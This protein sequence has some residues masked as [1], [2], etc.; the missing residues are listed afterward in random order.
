MAHKNYSFEFDTERR[1]R[2][3]FE[4]SPDA[5][6]R[7]DMNVQAGIPCLLLNRSAMITLAQTVIKFAHGAFTDGF[8]VHLQK[9][10]NADA[11]ERLT[12]FLP[13]DDAAPYR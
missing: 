1:N 4:Y 6:E 11:P 5:D 2:L 8:H 12:I 3:T 10:I 7:L 13:S 9:D